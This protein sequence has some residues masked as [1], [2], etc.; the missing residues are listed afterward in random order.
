MGTSHQ[1]TW[2]LCLLMSF[3]AG[4]AWMTKYCHLPVSTEFARPSK[5][6][7][8]NVQRPAVSCCSKL[9]PVCC[10]LQLRLQIFSL[11]AV[12]QIEAGKKALKTYNV[13][14]WLTQPKLFRT[15]AHQTILHCAKK[16]FGSHP[17]GC[18]QQLSAAPHPKY[19][20]CCYYYFPFKVAVL[21]GRDVVLSTTIVELLSMAHWIVF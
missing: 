21:L 19:I 6:V 13:W 2:M 4:L 17:W 1:L 15:Q 8:V 12:K 11:R 9:H 7:G 16:Y 3:E 5:E 14:W 10:L 20:L 18:L